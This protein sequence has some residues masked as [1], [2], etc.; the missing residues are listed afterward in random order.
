MTRFR[1]PRGWLLW[2]AVAAAVLLVAAGV[3]AVVIVTGE[4]G[5]V[6]HPDVEFTAPPT[7]TTQQ[8]KQPKSTKDPGFLWPTY[9]YNK[10]RTRYLP[11]KRPIHPPY[12]H[13]WYY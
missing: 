12:R 10:A 5:D 1:K 4:P 11:L 8:A 9:G 6:S 13:P 2:V 3:A 7:A